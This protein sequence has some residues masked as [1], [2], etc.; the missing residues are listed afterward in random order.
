MRMGR[1]N[2]LAFYTH[3]LSKLQVISEHEKDTILKKEKKKG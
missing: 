2:K 3:V 1:A